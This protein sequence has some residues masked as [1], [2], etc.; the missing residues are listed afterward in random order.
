MDRIIIERRKKKRL[1]IL[2]FVDIYDIYSG[3]TICSG[4][5]TNISTGGIQVEIKEEVTKKGEI[6]LGFSLPNGFIFSGIH[7][8]IV[9]KERD[10]FAYVYGIKFI[11]ISFK[12]KVKIWW[13]M[14]SYKYMLK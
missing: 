8:I 10:S 12:D 2:I 7:G 1:N 13:F 6:L 5:I 9:R 4:V 11:K 3:N 14:R